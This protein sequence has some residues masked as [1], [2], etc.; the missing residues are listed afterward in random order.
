MEELKQSDTPFRDHLLSIRRFEPMPKPMHTYV[1]DFSP[2]HNVKMKDS[3]MKQHLINFAY[4][5]LKVCKAETISK[6]VIINEENYKLERVTSELLVTARELQSCR[7]EIEASMILRHHRALTERLFKSLSR[8]ITVYTKTEP[9]TG[10]KIY[11]AEII[12]G[13]KQ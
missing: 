13:I 9:S 4:W 5:L 12:I 11:R 7:S 3:R 8:Y 2:Y 1:K 6:Y 10:N